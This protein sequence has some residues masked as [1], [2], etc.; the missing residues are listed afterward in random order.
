MY[1]PGDEVT[2][3]DVAAFGP[4]AVNVTVAAPLLY[5]RPV[6]MLVAVPI[7]GAAGNKLS[8][9]ARDF[10]PTLLFAAI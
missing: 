1:P 3:Y 6:P 5:A 2:V 10:L 9:C 4:C 8:F 7:N